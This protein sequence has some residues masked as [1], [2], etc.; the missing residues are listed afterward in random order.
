MAESEQQNGG[1]PPKISLKPKAED[2]PDTT[3]A[4]AAPAADAVRA[5]EQPSL[6]PRKPVPIRRPVPPTIPSAAPAQPVHPANQPTQSAQA[7][8]PVDPLPKTVAQLRAEAATPS[9]DSQPAI[10]LEPPAS[11]APQAG[12][13]QHQAYAQKAESPK[14]ESEEE[15]VAAAP[16]RPVLRPVGAAGSPAIRRPVPIGIR[17]EAPTPDADPGSKKATSRITLPTSEKSTTGQ[18]KTIKIAPRSATA[19]IDTEQPTELT[20][21]ATADPKRQTSRISLESVLSGQAGADPATIKIKRSPDGP[22]LRKPAPESPEEASSDSIHPGATPSN[23]AADEAKPESQK[24]TLKV[25]RS[26]DASG[27][28]P[29]V[30]ATPMFSPPVATTVARETDPHWIF[31]LTT[32]AAI[33][34]SAVLVY[35]IAAQTL[36]PDL[37]EQPPPGAGLAWPGRISQ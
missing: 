22:T 13:D 37:V 15:T 33:L 29:E 27:A 21:A 12:V 14:A 32:L 7:P 11:E 3:P 30:S 10:R 18:I 17:R 26:S 34:V 23:S 36:E 24:K 28:R 19:K 35:V 20:S 9:D 16:K 31:S 5:P 8:V 25:K 1:L 2:R 4:A 6:T